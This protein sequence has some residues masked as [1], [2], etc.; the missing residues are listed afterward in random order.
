MPRMIVSLPPET[1]TWLEE[2]G[3][4]HHLSAAEVIRRAL[5]LYRRQ[6]VSSGDLGEILT[7]TGGTWKSV[8]IDGRAYVDALRK[9]WD[10]RK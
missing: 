3:R 2:Y 9:E 1:K 4:R 5:K 6:G 8:R 10:G 7:R